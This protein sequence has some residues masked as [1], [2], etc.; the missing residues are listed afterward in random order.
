MCLVLR[1]SARHFDVVL[2]W[3]FTNHNDFALTV[4]DR[5]F[6]KLAHFLAPAVEVG[7]VTTEAL[8]STKLRE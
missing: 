4:R 3:K 5:S 8:Q 6:E 7:V 1:G 2:P